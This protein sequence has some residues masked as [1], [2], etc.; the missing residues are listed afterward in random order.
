MERARARSPVARASDASVHASG[1]WKVVS[2]RCAHAQ[3]GLAVRQ[4]LEPQDGVVGQRFR[5]LTRRV[6]HCV[7]PSKALAPE[8]DREPF[9]GPCKV[10]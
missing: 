8:P 2:F 10:G 6:W 5:S 7:Q 9:V 3:R 1:T 4:C